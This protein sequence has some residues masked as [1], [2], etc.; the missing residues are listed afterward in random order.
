MMATH[1]NQCC[2][3]SGESGAGKTESAKY[4]VEHVLAM[5]KGTGQLENRIME[6]NPLL[7]AFGNAKTVINDN[8]YAAAPNARIID[9]YLCHHYILCLRESRCHYSPILMK[10]PPPPHHRP[11]FSSSPPI[12]FIVH[13]HACTYTHQHAHTHARALPNRLALS[14]SFWQIRRDQVRLLR[15]CAWRAGMALFVHSARI[16]AEAFNATTALAPTWLSIHGPSPGLAMG[17]PCP[18]P[19]S[20]RTY[21]Q[22]WKPIHS[23]CLNRSPNLGSHS[24]CPN[25][26]SHSP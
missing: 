22:P 25:L 12:S 19:G 23:P 13:A 26:G 4:L 3:I 6:V 2:V 8:S 21:S 24:P 9:A 1:R 11:S 20:P 15:Q 18:N 7:E 10:P 14:E 16:Y 5:C 17:S